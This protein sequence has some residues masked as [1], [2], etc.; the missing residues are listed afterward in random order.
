MSSDGIHAFG[1]LLV[2][3][4][5]DP[6]VEGCSRYLAADVDHVK[7]RRWKQVLQSGDPSAIAEVLIP[8]IVDATVA[9]L[10]FA[11][12]GGLLHL[13]H[14]SENLSVDLTKDGGLEGWF[15]GGGVESWRA[16]Y[17]KERFFDDAK[18]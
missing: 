16:K 12:D 2:E 3:S 9:N 17:S 5:R 6:T 18:E 11:I 13:I 15:M 14:K 4:V 10:L 7:A 8:D 1:K